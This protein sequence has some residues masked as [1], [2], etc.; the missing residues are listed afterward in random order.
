MGIL[1][2]KVKEKMSNLSSNHTW[3]LDKKYQY[4]IYTAIIT[5]FLT[6]F[7]YIS[8]TLHN[9]DSISFFSHG[10]G[11][12]VD[13]GRWLLNLVYVAANKFCDNGGYFHT[14]VI[15]SVAVIF[16]IEIG[17]LLLIAIFEL[18]KPLECIT[19]TVVM[20]TF[21]TIVAAMLF[22]YLAALYAAAVTLS[23]L[24][25]WFVKRGKWYNLLIASILLAFGLGLYQA[26]FPYG[27]ALLVVLLI[28]QTA[29]KESD[30]KEIILNAIKYFG[31]LVMA[32]FIYML[33][34]KYYMW[35]YKMTAL[36][37]YQGINQMGK[38]D[39]VELPQTIL[40]TYQKF[41][42]V[43]YQNYVGLSAAKS[44]HILFLALYLLTLIA[45]VFIVIR[46]RRN[47]LKAVD[48]VVLLAIFPL[49]AN[50]IMIITPRLGI[51]TLMVMGMATVFYVPLVMCKAL[52][53][54]YHIQGI[55]RGIIC[56]VILTM[57]GFYCYQ[58]NVNYTELFY[59]NERTENF[60]SGLY[61]RIL[62]QPGYR[63]EMDI[64]FVGEDFLELSESEPYDIGELR[65]GGNYFGINV[66]SRKSYM[67]I[68]FGIKSR[69]ITEK[70]LETYRELIAR[71]D[72]YPSY[73]GIEI[74][75]EDMMIVK[76]EELD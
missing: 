7:Y 30:A 51:Y 29:S 47:I 53:S 23:A 69:E 70:E 19:L 39:L 73:S 4:S 46:E 50:S 43:T 60:V 66:Y 38:I 2:N 55:F 72:V 26:Y 40:L 34:L 14:I 57:G 32:Y 52:S 68:Y 10:V 71:M 12:G 64:V 63:K 16:L 17:C 54:A 24:A 22:N 8:R 9:Y 59:R 31:V 75:N 48:L 76:L 65:Y 37:P 44:M 27:A 67:D 3:K 62:S 5:G 36:S 74:V 49:A 11:A 21:P 18:E 1:I 42:S 45:G 41:F 35:K 56:S 15:N 25:I 58:A 6:Y 61:G 33:I 20:I 28:Q 13:F